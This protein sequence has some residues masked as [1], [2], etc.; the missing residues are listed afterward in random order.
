M[1][2]NLNA[3]GGSS[4]SWRNVTEWT[5]AEE[6]R[7]AVARE[8]FISSDDES[9][10]WDLDTF[11]EFGLPLTVGTILG[12]LVIGATIRALIQFAYKH[13]IWMR[14]LSLAYLLL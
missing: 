4:H 14:I 12:P 7:T 10:N 3:F 9:Q 5:G 1:G 13:R 11:W 6:N 2:M 8:S